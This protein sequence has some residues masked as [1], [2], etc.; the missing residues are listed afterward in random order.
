MAETVVDALVAKLTIDTTD[1]EKA[2]GEYQAILEKI[3]QNTRKA[4]DGIKKQTD[5]LQKN[6]GDAK[7]AIYGVRNSLLELLAVFIGTKD[8]IGFADEIRR[9]NT[10]L[11]RLSATTGISAQ[12]LSAWGGA[13]IAAGGSAEDA[14]STF[15][16]LTQTIQQVSTTGQSDTIPFFQAMGV[17]LLDSQRH[18]RN[19]QDVLLDMADWASK[20]DPAR[21]SYFLRSVGVSE[22]LIPLLLRGKPALEDYLKTMKAYAPTD[23]DVRA[24]GDLTRQYGLLEAS[25]G[26]LGATYLTELAPGILA[27]TSAMQKQLD[28]LNAHP[29]PESAVGATAPKPIKKLNDNAPGWLKPYLPTLEVMSLAYWTEVLTNDLFNY[30]G[31]AKYSDGSASQTPLAAKGLSGGAA[32][33]LRGISSAEGAGYDSLYGGGTFSGYGEFPQ[34]AGRKGP[35][36]LPTHAAGRYQFEPGTW[37]RAAKALG[38]KDFSPESQDKAA[39]WLAQQTYKGNLLTDLASNN[40]KAIAHITAVLSSQWAGLKTHPNALAANLGAPAAARASAAGSLQ[41]S[42]IANTSSNETHIGTI[43]LNGTGVTDS[44]SFARTV[45]GALDD[46]IGMHAQGGPQ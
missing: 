33:L 32:A 2:P 21:A 10:Q 13:A 19:F 4:S 8:I 35:T 24:A 5:G 36:G 38:L 6:F 7:S 12:T 17:Q 31:G 46:Q 30:W 34:W 44:Q 45:G 1:L 22:G 16:N 23:K 39:L 15:Q 41:Y 14:Y 27:V 11:G 26:K 40:P 37:A 28:W 43:N 3:E 29:N 20:Q 25:A 9:T 18:A 42:G